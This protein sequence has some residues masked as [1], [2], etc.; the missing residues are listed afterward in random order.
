MLAAV[1]P[2]GTKIA[3]NPLANYYGFDCGG[4]FL[5]YVYV[6]NLAGTVVNPTIK[7]QSSSSASLAFDE[8]SWV[9]NSRL[10]LYHDIENGIYFY[11]LGAATA[12]PWVESTDFQ[13]NAYQYPSLKSGKLATT[14]SDSAGSPA[15][16]LWTTNG[17][18]PTAPTARCDI[19]NPDP[20]KYDYFNFEFIVPRLA[21]DGNAVA[22]EE[23]DKTGSTPKKNIYVSPIGN[24]ATGGCSSLNRQLLIAGGSDPFWGPAALS[25]K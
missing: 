23:V 16:R 1:S 18:P 2:D 14:G 11:D 17:G 12:A 22:W 24:I 3:V 13:D 6:I 10:L 19:P 5:S 25:S 8:P 20:T 15:L 7:P 9:S 4:L 21:P